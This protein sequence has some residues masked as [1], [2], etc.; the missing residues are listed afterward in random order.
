MRKFLTS[1]KNFTEEEIK[2]GIC[3]DLQESK[4]NVYNTL[5]EINVVCQELDKMLVETHNQSFTG[6]NSSTNIEYDVLTCPYKYIYELEFKD[7][8]CFVKHKV[9]MFNY[10]L[11]LFRAFKDENIQFDEHKATIIKDAIQRLQANT[12]DV[13]RLITLKV[14]MNHLKEVDADF[15]N[16]IEFV[17]LV[18]AIEEFVQ[19]WHPN[20]DEIKEFL[21]DVLKEKGDIDA[22]LEEACYRLAFKFNQKE[23]IF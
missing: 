3:I 13:E 15:V 6:I 4:E 14:I 2:K 5:D 8:K 17:D 7:N 19:G 11:A 22:L 12:T 21:S 20:T 16:N 23:A 10:M 1:N 18:V 9:F